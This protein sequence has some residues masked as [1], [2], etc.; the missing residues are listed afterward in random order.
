MG[1]LVAYVAA[2]PVRYPSAPAFGVMQIIH[3]VIARFLIKQ[4][5]L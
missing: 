5:G 4:A 3:R 2:H 1:T